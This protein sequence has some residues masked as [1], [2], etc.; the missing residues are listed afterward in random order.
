MLV[1]AH[2][3]ASLGARVAG[4]YEDAELRKRIGAAARVRVERMFTLEACT[5]R[6]LNLYRG[7][8]AGTAGYPCAKWSTPC[9]HCKN[10]FALSLVRRVYPPDETLS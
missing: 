5:Q 1:P 8:I 10:L 3:P 7:L 6:Y 2:D 4:L 9:L